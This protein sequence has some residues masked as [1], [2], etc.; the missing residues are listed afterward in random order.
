MDIQEIIS[1]INENVT[2]PEQL[3]GMRGMGLS[4][5]PLP[6]SYKAKQQRTNSGIN[7]YI[8]H[9]NEETK[10]RIVKRL[11]ENVGKEFAKNKHLEGMQEYMEHLPLKDRLDN[12]LNESKQVI[13]TGAPG[14]GK[15]YTVRDYANSKKGDDDEVQVQF[16]QFHAS[17]DYSDFVEGLRPVQMLDSDNPTF[18]RLDGTFKRFCRDVVKVNQECASKQQPYKKHYFIIDEIN[19]ADLSNVFGELLF[20]L[21]ETNRGANNRFPTQYANLNTYEVKDGRAVL[22]EDDCFKDGFYVPENVYILG[23]M[24]DIDRSVEVFDFA[25]RRRFRW[26]EVK[27]NDEMRFVFHSMFNTTDAN[28]NMTEKLMLDDVEQFAQ[29]VIAMNDV[30][31]R[32][33]ELGLDEAYHIGPAYFKTYNG[34]NLETIWFERVEPILREYCRGRN[35]SV[36]DG[37]VWECKKEL[38]GREVE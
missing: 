25:L 15:T 27:A 9:R 16:V 1:Y 26:V 11:E 14:T 36:V 17:Y 28:D 31:A 37:F 4:L 32:K 23:T 21:E 19:R 10:A 24:N 34:D 35:K 6:E 2:C 33:T 12:I 18:V 3:H 8:C 38:F 29:R 22:V 5:E 7:Y 20:A 30:I 13:F